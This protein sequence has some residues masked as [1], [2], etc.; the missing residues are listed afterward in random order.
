MAASATVAGERG[1]CGQ[2][3]GGGQR[4]VLGSVATV[5]S[6]GMRA[7]IGMSGMRWLP[8]M[9]G[10]HRLCSTAGRWTDVRA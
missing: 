7:C 2:C 4:Q 10:L 1:H 5:S 9:R 8:L 6:A 3:R